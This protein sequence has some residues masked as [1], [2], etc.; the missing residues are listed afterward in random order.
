MTT[1]KTATP[2]PMGIY[3]LKGDDLT[4]QIA[5]DTVTRM[6]KLETGDGTSPYIRRQTSRGVEVDVLEVPLDIIRALRRRNRAKDTTLSFTAYQLLSNGLI[7]VQNERTLK[8]EAPVKKM[9]KMIKDLPKRSAT[10]ARR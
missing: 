7:R 10:A 8:D 4:F 1:K 5:L 3:Y 2:R 9:R 6:G